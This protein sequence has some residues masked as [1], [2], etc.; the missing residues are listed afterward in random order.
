MIVMSSRTDD[1][2]DDLKIDKLKLI[3]RLA[4]SRLAQE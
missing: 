4:T 2:P 1:R 3:S